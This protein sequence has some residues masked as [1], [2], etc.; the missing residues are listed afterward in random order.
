MQRLE[1]PETAE[2]SKDQLLPNNGK[3][4]AGKIIYESFK[5]QT[6][7][8]AKEYVEHIMSARRVVPNEVDEIVPH[9]PEVAPVS[10]LPS[11]SLSEKLRNY[12]LKLSKRSESNFCY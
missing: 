11:E 5:P 3:R 10:E 4:L 12:F 9:Y 2:A 8:E 1:L 6:L 7:E